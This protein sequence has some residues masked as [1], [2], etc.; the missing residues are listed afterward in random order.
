MV[1]SQVRFRR[2]ELLRFGFVL[3]L[4]IYFSESD[5]RFRQCSVMDG[6]FS[7]FHGN[8][9]RNGLNL[10]RRLRK[11]WHFYLSWGKLIPSFEKAI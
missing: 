7:D 11:C 4:N 1:K 2:Y 10:R 9:V 3:H 5:R 8:L 6:L